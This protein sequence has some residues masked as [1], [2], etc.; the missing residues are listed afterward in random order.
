M[1]WGPDGY[2]Y[3]ADWAGRHIVRVAKDGS[4]DDLPFWKTTMPLQYDG[5]RSVAFDS[6]GN[7]FT[8]NHGSIFRLDSSGNVTEL[9][10]IQ[11][12]PIGSLTISPADELYYSDRAQQGGALRKWDPSG[13]SET[14]VADLPF[15]ENMVFGLD[16][17]LYL[18]QMAQ[19]QIL[20]VNVETGEVT[21]FQE[22][23]CGNDPCFLAIDPEGDIWARGINRLTQFTPQGVV[24]PFVVD[25]FEYPG[26]PYYWH[27]AAGIAFDNEG[28]L[29]I[30]S[31]NSW[32]KRLVPLTPGEADPEFTLQTISPGLEVCDLDMDK[33]GNLYATDMNGMQILRF[34]PDGEM[35][36]LLDLGFDGRSAIALGPD[37]VVHVGLPNGEIVRLEADG[38]YSHYASLTTR[39]MV[40]GVDGAL[41][42]IVGD[43]G[44]T[45]SI[46]R[47]T[48][49]DTFSTLASEIEGIPLGVGEAHISPAL[50]SGF[51]V[52][53]EQDRNLFFVDYEGQGHLIA[54]LR[55]L[56]GGGPVVM[57]ASPV[58]GDI[59]FI[60]HGPYTVFR[61]DP[62]GNSE[63]VAY[64]VFGDPWGMVVSH[65]GQ[66]LYV[67]E[68]GVI[69][70]IPISSGS[71]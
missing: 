7:L 32:L 10:G 58:T 3:I 66:W 12:S 6:Q 42:A 33:E 29:W 20:K 30:A 48:A 24:K 19:P 37:G 21:I 41:Y 68:S 62:E 31:Y 64:N 55:D 65:D 49:V 5:P 1:T 22:D 44:Q 57:A 70:R 8:N 18:T 67:A 71:N 52:F 51:Y 23:V 63:E 40:F 60:P 45:K 59:Y 2:L 46:A 38:S 61:I 50:D 14:I 9:Q 15:A 53:T 36:V 16:G 54:N 27:T 4:M 26:L 17:S 11:G 13:R 56:G 28:G 69:D 34:K 43:Y 25:G 47:I 35:D 39:R